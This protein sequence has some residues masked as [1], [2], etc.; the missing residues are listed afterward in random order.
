MSNLFASLHKSHD[1][2]YYTGLKNGR[3]EKIVTCSKHQ[4]E[5]TRQLF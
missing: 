2:N 1:Q 3:I 4:S 5:L